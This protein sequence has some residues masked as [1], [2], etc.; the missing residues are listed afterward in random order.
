MKLRSVFIQAIAVVPLPIQLSKTVSPSF[1]YVFIRY[2]NN[3]TGF[4]VGC[5][6]CFPITFGYSITLCGK[7]VY[8]SFSFNTLFCIVLLIF[9]SSFSSTF[10]FLLLLIYCSQYS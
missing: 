5:I 2:S 3:G 10:F 1:V 4:W 7:P 9:L 6:A 8:A